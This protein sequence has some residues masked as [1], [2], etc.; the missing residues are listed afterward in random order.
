MAVKAWESWLGP[1]FTELLPQASGRHRSTCQAC[2]DG[3]SAWEPG[4]AASAL[5]PTADQPGSSEIQSHPS[6]SA[7]QVSPASGQLVKAAMLGGA[8][9]RQ[10]LSPEGFWAGPGSCPQQAVLPDASLASAAA[11]TAP[12]PCPP[13][14][15]HRPARTQW[16]GQRAHRGEAASVWLSRTA[17]EPGRR[18]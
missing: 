16:L 7:H 1:V 9:G 13:H 17:C 15:H 10:H 2:L 8:E 3:G 11:P 5:N 14:T 4:E 6:W 18:A 12:L